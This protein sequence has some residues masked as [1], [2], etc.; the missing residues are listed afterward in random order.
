M[1]QIL[2][3][4]HPNGELRIR[5]RN[6]IRKKR[7]FDGEP[8]TDV[9]AMCRKAFMP[10]SLD[11]KNEFQESKEEWMAKI[12]SSG[13]SVRPGWGMCPRLTKFGI[14]GR[15]K[16]LRAGG[17]MDSLPGVRAAITLTLPGNTSEAIQTICDYSGFIANRVKTWLYDQLVD[18]SKVSWFYV[19]ELQ[20]RGALH[21]H[22]CINCEESAVFRRIQKGIKSAWI[23]IL[24]TVGKKASVNMFLSSKGYDWRRKRGKIQVDCQRVKKSV[25]AY[26]AKY[27]GK[28]DKGAE[29][30][31]KAGLRPSRWWGCS[32]YL[33][34]LTQLMR[35]SVVSQEM[36]QSQAD[37]VIE[38]MLDA[39][40]DVENCYLKANPY[41]GAYYLIA[42]PGLSLGS[43]II[44]ELEYRLGRNPSSSLE[45][46]K[47]QNNEL[48]KR[49]KNI[50]RRW[51][52]LE[53]RLRLAEIFGT[54]TREW[55]MYCLL[56]LEP[57][58][59]TNDVVEHLLS[60]VEN[61]G[62]PQ[63]DNPGDDPDFFIPL[64]I[65]IDGL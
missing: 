11:N 58:C 34:R 46:N 3:E 38:G 12:L 40:E 47:L 54:G 28:A 6:V 51:N 29:E 48:K 26:F 5:Y 31:I 57:E 27:C 4:L 37:S 42:Y 20:K 45:A 18:P 16:I 36:S 1:G 62:N 14:R 25:S 7:G 9:K 35:I 53:E 56:M 30:H 44:R 33:S 59:V 24:E 13:E 52:T 65:T 8:R 17:V 64:Q 60:I 23:N 10:S 19:W 49:I 50:Q 39:C 22:L 15:R 43:E 41:T 21:M 2:A 32:R 61:D 63:V 55:E